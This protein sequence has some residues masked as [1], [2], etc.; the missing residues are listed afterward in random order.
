MATAVKGTTPGPWTFEQIDERS[1]RELGI[2]T[3]AFWI[4]GDYATSDEVVGT[5]EAISLERALADAQLVAAAPDLLT[6]CRAALNDRQYKDWPGIA[7]LLIA[8]IAKAEGR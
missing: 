6:A 1:A 5:V 7:D 3:P 8:A 4:V 2:E